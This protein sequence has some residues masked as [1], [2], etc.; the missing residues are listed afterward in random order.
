MVNQGRGKGSPFDQLLNNYNV[1]ALI[2]VESSGEIISNNLI[3]DN[4][5]KLNQINNFNLK[6]LEQIR[7]DHHLSIVLY[8][9]QFQTVPENADLGSFLCKKLHENLFLLTHVPK[10]V[11][12]QFQIIDKPSGGGFHL[13]Y[14]YKPATNKMV[15]AAPDN[16]RSLN[17][18]AAKDDPKN[19]FWES[20]IL[21][22]DLPVYRNAFRLA[23]KNGGDHHVKYRIKTQG[24]DVFEVIDYFGLSTPEGS[25]PEI[26]GCIV[27]RQEPAQNYKRLER[28]CLIGRLTGGMIHD[29]RNLLGGMQNMILWSMDQVG[30][31]SDVGEKLQKTVRYM[32]Q[33]HELIQSTLRIM[34]GK[35]NDKIQPFDMAEVVR[36]AETFVQHFVSRAINIDVKLEDD[37]PAVMGQKSCMLDLTLNLCLNACDAMKEKGN[38]LT[39]EVFSKEHK[40]EHG[41]PF[42]SIILRVIDDGCGMTEEQSRA[43]FKE[44]YTTKPNGAGL[45]LWTVQQAVRSFDGTINVQSSL[46][47]GSVF[48]IAFPVASDYTEI[49]LEESKLSEKVKNNKKSLKVSQE[50]FGIDPSELFRL[51]GKTI[52]YIEDEPLLRGGITTWFE[53]LGLNV[54]VAED[55]DKGKEIYD[56]HKQKIDLIVQDYIIPGISGEKLL[57]IFSSDQDT[58]IPILVCSGFPDGRDY[59]WLCDKGASG[60][61]SKPFKIDDLLKIILEYLPK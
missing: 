33:A 27:N 3:A 31:E 14:L 12:N 28:L 53:S 45:G 37:L 38:N 15:F 44:F 54:L 20:C 18:L 41:T 8:E 11:E 24:G 13:S 47:N 6:I 60:F 50:K 22:D 52:L 51:K 5:L 1:A 57:E 26:A 55:G 32:E 7:D 36:D 61:I 19:F 48:S 56:K 30:P 49:L 29:F 9:D 43:I 59:Q 21:P 2:I 4:F 23:L 46:G 42:K 35:R 10:Q 34:D 17:L 39:I 16:L 58:N 40:A 25:W